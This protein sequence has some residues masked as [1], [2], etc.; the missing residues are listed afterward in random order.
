[1]VVISSPEVSPKALADLKEVGLEA[2]VTISIK[3][4]GKVFESNADNH[5]AGGLHMWK[6]TAWEGRVSFKF[7]PNGS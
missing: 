6:R 4:D 5:S 2:S 7:D 1:M 3:V